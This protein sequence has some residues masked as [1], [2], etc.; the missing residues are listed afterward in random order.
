MLVKII[1]NLWLNVK[2]ILK[3]TCKIMVNMYVEI[4]KR[5]H[6]YVFFAINYVLIGKTLAFAVRLW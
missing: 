6:N 1:H 3:L 5:I 2:I 4:S